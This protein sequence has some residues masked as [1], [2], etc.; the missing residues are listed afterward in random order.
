MVTRFRVKNLTERGGYIGS[1]QSSNCASVRAR[2]A[3]RP[4]CQ[5]CSN[6]PSQ[7][8]THP[9]SSG[10][11]VQQI[12]DTVCSFIHLMMQGVSS[13]RAARGLVPTQTD[14]KPAV[15][16]PSLKPACGVRHATTID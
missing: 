9:A 16:T 13:L 4:V 7:H 14:G 3:A 10:S 2:H 5:Q 11:A 6:T 1:I 12:D 15:G 8:C